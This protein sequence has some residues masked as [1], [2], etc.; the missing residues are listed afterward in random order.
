[1]ELEPSYLQQLAIHL[2]WICPNNT[3]CEHRFLICG[4]LFNKRRLKLDIDHRVTVWIENTLELLN[5]KI[6]N[7]L[8]NVR[9]F[10]EKKGEE[11]NDN[12][13]GN[14]QNDNEVAG[15]GILN[16]NVDDL[17]KEFED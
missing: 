14:N 9:E 13:N 11:T 3:S 15:R 7:G 12:V 2:F 1:M 16:Y 6:L 10:L 8:E 17:M 5:P 4:W